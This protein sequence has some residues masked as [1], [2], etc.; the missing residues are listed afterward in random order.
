MIRKYTNRRTQIL[1]LLN[2]H[3]GIQTLELDM[4]FY[5]LDAK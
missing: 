4:L 2:Q 3:F 5:L 1:V